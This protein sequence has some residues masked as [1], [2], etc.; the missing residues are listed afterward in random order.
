M[1]AYRKIK[2]K[3]DW[4]MTIGRFSHLFAS[5]KVKSGLFI[6]PRFKMMKT[7]NSFCLA[8]N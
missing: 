1:R 5:I 3:W 8:A 7:I 2:K 6:H 4:S